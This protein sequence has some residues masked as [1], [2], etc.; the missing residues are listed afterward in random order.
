MSTTRR[1]DVF[2][3]GRPYKMCYKKCDL[4]FSNVMNLK[5]Q[6]PRFYPDSADSLTAQHA[7]NML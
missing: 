7:N 1:S 3:M 6:L 2:L 5:M 4:M